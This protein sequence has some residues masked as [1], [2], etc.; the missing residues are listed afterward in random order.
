MD[1]LPESIYIGLELIKKGE[2]FDAH[3]VIEDAWRNEPGEI[4]QLFQGILQVAVIYLHISKGNSI[5]AQKM[6]HRALYNLSPYTDHQSL[7]IPDVIY[8]LKVI[9]SQMSGKD[10]AQGSILD[11]SLLKPVKL[12]Q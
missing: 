5:G 11:P 8:N 1:Q 9:Q 3:E 10:A 12:R 7:D 6:L 4:R 2:Y